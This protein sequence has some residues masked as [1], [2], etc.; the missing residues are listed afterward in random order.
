M[1]TLTKTFRKRSPE[2]NF[3]QTLFSLVRVDRRK[4]TFSETVRTLYQ[5]QSIPQKIRKIRDGGRA[6][7]FFVFYTRA[8]F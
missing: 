4:R 8:Y 2:W 1:K 5:L 3:L 7:P 6:F